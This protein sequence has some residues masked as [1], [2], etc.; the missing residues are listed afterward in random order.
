MCISLESITLCI[1]AREQFEYCQTPH[2]HTA[3][4]ITNKIFM[5]A[6]C[7][8]QPRPLKYSTHSRFVYTLTRFIQYSLLLFCFR[9]ALDKYEAIIYIVLLNTYTLYLQ[10]NTK[11]KIANKAFVKTKQKK[12]T[13]LFIKKCENFKKELFAFWY[14][15]GDA[16]HT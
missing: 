6:N 13:R 7:H 10:K 14:I 12:Q 4:D 8:S 5:K 3:V 1:L 16:V 2:T 15:R 9:S 11:K